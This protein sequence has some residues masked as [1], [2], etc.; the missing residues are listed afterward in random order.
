MKN[1][2]NSKL[3]KKISASKA[4]SDNDDSKQLVFNSSKQAMK[5]PFPDSA[6][7]NDTQEDHT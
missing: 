5:F 3:K 7:K 4:N 6:D 2:W 1:H